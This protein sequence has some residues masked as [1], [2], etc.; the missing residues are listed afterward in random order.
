[1]VKMDSDPWSPVSGYSEAESNCGQQKPATYLIVKMMSTGSFDYSSSTKEV[2]KMMPEKT[3]MDIEDIIK[4]ANQRSNPDQNNHY[5]QMLKEADALYLRDPNQEDVKDLRHHIP[6]FRKICY[7]PKDDIEK[8]FKL[9]SMWT[10]R[11]SD[12][13]TGVLHVDPNNPGS[14]NGKK[15]M[16]PKK[17]EL[18]KMFDHLTRTY[19]KLRDELFLETFGC[20]PDE[21]SVD[22]RIKEEFVDNQ[23]SLRLLANQVFKVYV[24]NQI[25]K[26]VNALIK[27]F[28]TM[29]TIS[30]PETWVIYN[31]QKG[32]LESD[33]REVI[34]LSDKG[35]PHPA[36]AFI[37]ELKGICKLINLNAEEIL[38]SRMEE[39]DVSQIPLILDQAR[40]PTV[41]QSRKRKPTFNMDMEEVYQPQQNIP[42]IEAN[43]IFEADSTLYEADMD[44]GNYV[45]ISTESGITTLV[46]VKQETVPNII[47]EGDRAVEALQQAYA[48]EMMND[49][50]QLH[51][52][53]RPSPGQPV[54]VRWDAEKNEPQSIFQTFCFD[55]LTP[56]N[57]TTQP[58]ETSLPALNYD[59]E[60]DVPV[61]LD[62]DDVCDIL[63]NDVDWYTGI[64]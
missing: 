30:K 58:V 18:T 45:D 2:I 53:N 10:E 33:L 56:G 5:A 63:R 3:R 64:H 55:N 13:P 7:I 62:L 19:Q 11:P 40:T 22:S 6:L 27:E 38:A 4:I 34:F 59:G 12:W 15:V 54:D 31:R 57:E 14:V 46:E 21:E 20:R 28:D 26:L 49:F 24:N 44:V 32:I 36:D 16:K 48:P 35:C 47:E 23:N 17:P 37:T 8:K 52:A 29:D 1:M 51:I 9:K 50:S 39:D 61:T 25:E 42:L 60:K 43:S 41:T